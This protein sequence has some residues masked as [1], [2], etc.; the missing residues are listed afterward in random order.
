MAAVPPRFLW[1]VRFGIALV[2]L[3]EG[4]WMKLLHRDPH[5]V[6]I[7]AAV[8]APYPLSPHL[9]LD[10]IGIGETLIAIGVLS[11]LFPR[12]LA[13]FQIVLLLT[14]NLIAICFGQGTIADPIGLLIHNLP[15]ILCIVLVGWYPPQ[16]NG[17]A[18]P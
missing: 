15:L 14:M 5:E 3:H 11:G 1:L 13:T 2:W 16:K 18:K 9:F 8:G 4:L 10:L 17:E 6:S 7:V 12:F